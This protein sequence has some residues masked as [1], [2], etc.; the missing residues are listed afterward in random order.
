MRLVKCTPHEDLRRRL[1]NKKI[2]IT[3][4]LEVG[5]STTFRCSAISDVKVVKFERDQN[6][7]VTEEDDIPAD[8]SF[9][10]DTRMSYSCG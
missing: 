9:D 3:D 10:M 6:V 7:T 1:E 4:R 5:L 2:I 8:L